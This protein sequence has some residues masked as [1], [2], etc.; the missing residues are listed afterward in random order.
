MRDDSAFW[1]AARPFFGGDSFPPERGP[2]KLGVEVDWR[3]LDTDPRWRETVV[4]LFAGAAS[5]LG[6]FYA[7]GWVEPGWEVSRNNRLW[8]SAG[9]KTRGRP[10]GREGW[11]GLPR[12]AGVAVVV[13][14]PLPRAGGGGAGRGPLRAAGASA[15]AR[16]RRA[17]TR[18]RRACS[19]GS[20]NSRGRS[21]RPSRLPPELVRPRG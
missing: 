18:G 19:S 16:R 1:F 12:R 21:S 5:A 9:R 2:G 20:A 10:I 8:I 13:R 14:R 11:E 3:V 15:G 17:S 7:E 4:D 6:A